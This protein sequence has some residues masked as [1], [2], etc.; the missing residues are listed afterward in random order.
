LV[1]IEHLAL[2]DALWGF[3]GVYPSSPLDKASKAYCGAPTDW[4]QAVLKL[5]KGRM[6]RDADL[7]RRLMLRI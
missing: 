6:A 1:Y 5:A 4:K 7:I 2:A 3:A